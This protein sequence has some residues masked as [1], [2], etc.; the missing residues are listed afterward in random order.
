MA[1]TA[2]DPKPLLDYLDKEGNIMG[3]LVVF[4]LGSGALLLERIAGANK[5]G[6]LS[7]VWDRGQ[8]FVLTAVG[9]LLA[10]AVCFYRQRSTLMWVHGLIS[11]SL[12]GGQSIT[13]HLSTVDR[14]MFW[15][16]YRVAWGFVILALVQ[17]GFAFASPYVTRLEAPSVI[18]GM[19]VAS[20]AVGLLIYLPWLWVLHHRDRRPS[21]G[22]GSRDPWWKRRSRA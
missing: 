9:L 1:D 2:P 5:P 6:Y 10:G 22:R 3:L 8:F 13:N 4:C 12:A 17:A 19:I 15:W 18:W 11:L 20:A 7:L 16:E 21:Q 14:W